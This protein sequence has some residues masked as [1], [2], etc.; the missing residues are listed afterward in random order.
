[1][2]MFVVAALSL[3]VM[4]LTF[5]FLA[6][7][8]QVGVLFE[9]ITPVGA[10]VNESGPTLGV[11]AP[12]ATLESLTGGEV[13]VG[14]GSASATLLF[15]LSP[16]CPVC[17][18]LLPVLREIRQSEAAWLNIVLASDGDR[19][20]HER[21]IETAKLSAFP[22]VLSAELG[23]SYRVARLPFSV[24]IDTGGKVAA[25]GLVNNRE[26]IESLFNAADM[27]VSSIQA[28]MDSAPKAAR[29]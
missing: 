13:T 15:F 22:Y 27:K 23:L 20:R 18:K 26:Q 21:F 12:A 16:N 10:L 25:K 24:L 28:Y 19:A 4:A 3:A 7:A 2:L 1:M 6:L 9:R 8:R 11:E 5:A 17:K 29:G 14:R